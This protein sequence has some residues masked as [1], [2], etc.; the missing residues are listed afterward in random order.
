VV[1]AA[2]DAFGRL[3]IVVNNV[4]GAVPQPFLETSAEQLEEAFHFNVSTAHALVR[5]A[6][7]LMLENGGGSV[8]SRG[9][10]DRHRGHRGDHQ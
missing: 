7:P 6:V 1:V 5:S 10:H 9:R 8:V 3:D 4:G 2:R